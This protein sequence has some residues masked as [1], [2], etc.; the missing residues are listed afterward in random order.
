[1]TK[2]IT[3]YYSTYSAYAYI[4]HRHFLEIAA[5][6][7]RSIVHRPFD[8]NRCLDN[9]G[10]QPWDD[11]TKANLDYHFERQRMRW[12]AFRGVEMPQVT[13][14]TH[15]N[16]ADVGDR[17]VIAGEKLGLDVDALST[18][19]LNNHWQRD[20]DLSRADLV[21]DCLAQ[22]G[23]DTGPLFARIEHP[24]V[25]A[26]YAAN[27]DEAIALPLFGSPS[28]VV[29]GDMFYG[30]DNLVLVEQALREPFA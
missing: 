23:I 8:L 27:T 5:R 16:A 13:P 24:D 2:S 1:M 6:A 15:S 17:A 4:G 7:G 12:S 14:S 19:L 11:R 30:Q 9:N 25:A 20:L 22:N 26:E 21:R 28:Y 3:Y 18:L 29:D 10:S